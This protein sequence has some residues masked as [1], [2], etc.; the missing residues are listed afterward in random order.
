MPSCCT[1]WTYKK[2]K[3]ATD[4]FCV[5]HSYLY[6]TQNVSCLPLPPEGRPLECSSDLLCSNFTVTLKAAGYAS[7]LLSRP[8]S[9]FRSPP[10][11][12]F[13]PWGPEGLLMGPGPG[14]EGSQSWPCWRSF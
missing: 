10:F 9:V 13:D 8:Q 7:R 2:S 4:R 14:A 6:C 1:Q 12:S 5:A 3:V 11:G